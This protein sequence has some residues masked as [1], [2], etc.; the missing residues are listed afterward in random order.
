MDLQRFFRLIR[1]KAYFSTTP[2]TGV[3]NTAL[4]NPRL[5]SS[6]SLGL[7]TKSHFRPPHSSHPVETFINFV[8]D[9]FLS[10]KND[11]EKGNLFYPPNLTLEERHS[12]RNLQGDDTIIMKLADKGG[13]LVIMDKTMYLA[14]ITRQL[15][16][17]SV[18]QILDRDPSYTI[19]QEIKVILHKYMLLGI[20][21]QKTCSYLT[22]SNPTTPVYYTFPKILENPPGRPIVASTDSLLSP[23]SKYLEKIITPLIQQS[24]SFLDRPQTQGHRRTITPLSG[25][26]TLLQRLDLWG[27]AFLLDTSSFL[28]LIYDINH[29]PVDALLVTLDVRDLY[30]SIP[31]VEGVN[32]V[33]RLLEKTA[34]DVRG[35]AMGSHA[36]PPYAN[37]YMIDFE[38]SVIYKHHLFRDNVIVWKRYIDDVFCI[39]GGSIEP[40]N[41]FLE[42]LNSSWPDI[43]F[44][45]SYNLWSMNFLDTLVIKSPDGCLSTDLYSK[46]SAG[47]HSA[48]DRQQKST[49]RN[50]LLHFQSLHP[51][52]T[53]RS[54][55][56]AQYHGVHRIVSDIQTRDI[57][58]REMTDKFQARGYP[59]PLLEEARSI[60]SRPRTDTK[61]RIP[62]VHTFHP[63]MYKL[64]KSIRK[65]WPILSTAY[66]DIPEFKQPFLPCFK[67]APSLRDTF[68]RA[69]IGPNTMM[70]QRFLHKPRVGTFPCL[71]CAQCGNVLKGDKV[72][73]PYSGKEF[74]IRGYFTCSSE[75]VVYMIKCPCGLLYVGE[76]SQSIRDRISKHKST[77]RCENLLL[78]IPHHF[79]TKGHNISQ[80]RFQVLEQISLP[81]RVGKVYSN[82]FIIKGKIT[83]TGYIGGLST[84][85]Q[86]AV[87]KPLMPVALVYMPILGPMV[88]TNKTCYYL[89][90][91]ALR[92]KGVHRRAVSSARLFFPLDIRVLQDTAVDM[93]IQALCSSMDNLVALGLLYDEPNSVDQAEKN[94][95]ALCQGQDD[96]EVYCQKFR[97][98]SVLTLWN[99]SAL[100]ALF[101]KGLSE[102]L[103]DVLV[104]FPMPAG[105][106]ESMSLAIQIGRRLRERKS[107]H[108]LAVL[109]ESKPEPMQC[110]RTMT[111]VERHEHRRLNRLCFYCGDS[112]HAIS[113]CPKRT[114]RFD[115]S[116]VIGTV[117]SKFLLSITLMC[118]LSSY[119]VMAFVDSGAALNLMDL[120]Y[121]KRC[122]FFLEPLRCPIPLR[123]IDATPLA[124]NKPQYWAQ[125]TMCMAPAHQEVIRFLVL[126]NLHDV[127][128]LGLPWLQTH[129]P[130]LDW[131]SMSVTSWGCQGVHGDVPFLSISSSI[132][133]DIPE[134]LSDFQDVFEESKSDALPPHR[135]CDLCYRFDSW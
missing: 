84:A 43:S 116:A 86:N 125:L 21:D 127:V 23:I 30:T 59:L 48:G 64:H 2:H 62:F 39:W 101:R 109:S 120:D 7:R 45:I 19:R 22:N 1:L 66:P 57:R 108:H 124:K 129:N 50:S 14:E 55:A 75:Y 72:I 52:S 91:E 29:I 47:K 3:T 93:D 128:V 38:E 114:R 105:L 58:T 77:I 103:K 98:W 68:V 107:V 61:E 65:N 99:E 26:A 102:A 20:L 117:Q 56:K 53:K 32:S 87:D 17:V 85:L 69:D 83:M 73:H 82:F 4:V 54:I 115:S 13:A 12:L 51:P 113:N 8:Q 74:K 44:T 27:A 78:P 33:R 106:N 60:S 49:D 46:V 24:K 15:S 31:H 37:A 133:S 28:Q 11:V 40:L 42:V 122:G 5:L 126:H 88:Y 80:L 79:H 104:G 94:L 41:M 10:L 34:M 6:N 119:S 9:S 135:N 25:R 134:F 92:S 97:K 112:T 36:A 100:A 121:A 132:P 90:L 16:D 96:V 118:S 70:R 35:T 130:V 111:K 71:H 18:Y 89:L 95:L 81:R 63:F 123:G 131:N 67:R 110:D 76:T